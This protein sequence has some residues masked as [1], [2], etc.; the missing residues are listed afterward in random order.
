MPLYCYWS[1]STS[2]SQRLIYCINFIG[3]VAHKG[4]CRQFH[5]IRNEQFYDGKGATIDL[6]L[7]C[8]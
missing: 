1:A 8:M 7:L 3:S 5:R 2:T 4:R 6:C